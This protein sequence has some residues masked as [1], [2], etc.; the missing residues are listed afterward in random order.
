MTD[1]LTP[2]RVIDDVSTAAAALKEGLL[3]AFPTET[4]YG[5]G[6]D[7]TNPAA[8]ARL[9]KA[10]GR[11]SD[12]PLIVHLADFDQWPKAASEMSESA[13]RLMKEFSPGPITVVTRKN[14]QI[15]DAVTA[16]L[17]SVGIRIPNHH[18][19][20]S[21][22]RKCGRPIAAP[23]A[24]V[25]GRPSCTTW[26][27]VLEDMNGRIDFILKG[28]VCRIGIESTVV[29]CTIA[30]ARLLRAGAITREQILELLPD[31]ASWHSPEAD[32]VVPSPGMRHPHY[33]PKAAVVLVESISDLIQLTIDQLRHTAYAG[34]S[35]PSDERL[36]DEHPQLSQLMLHARFPTIE[37]YMREFYEFLREADRKG[38]QKI[39]L[40]LAP[41]S[42]LATAL[43]DRQSRA[44][45]Q[46]TTVPQERS[47]N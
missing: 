1:L 23:S 20:Q 11:P 18:L 42:G 16:G 6:V 44:A 39:F 29:D 32:G 27:S 8:V 10:K 31:V 40:Q 25:S 38:A 13:L 7:A 47:E 12:N 28:D 3:V 17:S 30:P 21:L 2:T 36:L 37:L 24:N 41:A 45:G 14:L 34:V 4:V 46:P 19:A 22:L 5:L 9:F 43:R 15:D 26:Q 35:F 33:Q